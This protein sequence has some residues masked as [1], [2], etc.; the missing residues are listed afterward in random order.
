MP[1]L[2]RAECQESHGCTAVVELEKAII[3]PL[4]HRDGHLAPE[5]DAD[6]VNPLIENFL[7]QATG[8]S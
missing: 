1:P 8:R 7:I 2:S 4:A 3:Y 5:T 6:A